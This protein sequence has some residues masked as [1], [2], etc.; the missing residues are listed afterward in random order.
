MHYSIIIIVL[1]LYNCYKEKDKDTTQ[2]GI[3]DAWIRAISHHLNM[4]KIITIKSK[5][6]HAGLVTATVYE[7]KH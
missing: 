4:Y 5:E 6:R 3:I 7:E 1:S 2:R